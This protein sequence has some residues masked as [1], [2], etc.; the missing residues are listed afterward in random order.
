[1]IKFSLMRWA[2]IRAKHP[3]DLCCFAQKEKLGVLLFS[4]GQVRSRDATRKQLREWT[5][6][7]LCRVRGCPRARHGKGAQA[8]RWRV[9]GFNPVILYFSNLPTSNLPV[10][11]MSSS[12]AEVASPAGTLAKHR[13]RL[14]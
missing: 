6:P 3:F 11:C 4:P 12:E 13:Q 1:M 10:Q 5:R 14:H 9:I 7:F 2:K 8:E